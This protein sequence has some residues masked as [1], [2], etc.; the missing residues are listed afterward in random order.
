MTLPR[1]SRLAPLLAAC[2]LFAAPASGQ[3]VET[4]RFT[5]DREHTAI[6]FYVSHLGFSDMVGRI[7]EFDG[8]FNFDP[9]RPSEGSVQVTMKP[10][11]IETSSRAL[12]MKLQNVDFFDSD[13]F[14]VITFKS[15]A[16]N[17]TGTDTADIIGD[18]TMRGLTRP[19]VLKVKFNKADFNP[20]SGAYVAGFSATTTIR[21]SDFGMTI[22][23]P[24]VGDD[25]RIAIQLE[26]TNAARS[27]AINR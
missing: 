25:V 21:R 22:Y 13:R 27:K 10:S 11:S 1:F 23:N 18:L 12:D 14:P 9:E 15:T 16:I 24:A 5:L 8:A 3:P 20:F 19:V 6:L 26:G 7:T 17:T 4:N 2:V